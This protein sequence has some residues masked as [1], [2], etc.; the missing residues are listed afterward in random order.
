M[1]EKLFMTALSPT[2]EQGTVT[3]WHKKEGDAVS[4]GDVLCEVETD[5]AVM[6]YESDFDAVLLKILVN[7]GQSA[8]VGDVIGIY[9]EAGE[10]FSGL[11]SD[12]SVTEVDA[13][14]EK[15]AVKKE[16]EAFAPDQPKPAALIP[17]SGRRLKASPL[18]RKMA[19][20][21]N[22]N[23]E[24]VSGSGFDGR[25][26]KR[27]ILEFSEKSPA[28]G[29]T[30]AADAVP[31][32]LQA[33]VKDVSAMRKTIAQRLSASKF[34]AP[35]F[36]L[37][38][39]ADMTALIAAREAY[40]SR[41]GRK[42]SFNSYLI[43]LSA[44]ALQK[45]PVVNSSW[46]GDRIRGFGTADIGFA[47]ALKE[48]LITPVIRNC[49]TKGI[50]IIDDEFQDLAGRAKNGKLSPAEYTGAGF[51]ISNLGSYGI[52]EF[53]AIINPPGSAILAVGAVVKTPAVTT[54]TEGNDTIVTKPLVKLTLSCD[55]RVI[56]GAEGASFLADLKR[57]IENPV[58]ALM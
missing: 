47:A 15:P 19:A 13:P 51:T 24:A 18:A 31:A 43:R 25:I 1:A 52:E 27:D 14:P 46:E 35:H 58:E 49:E 10:D 45:H 2:M 50:L 56:D 6:E 30:A 7:N 33:T 53:T 20:D 21:L 41:T 48:G 22:I 36:Y 12:I 57:M 26:I 42:I 39:S 23:I 16:P 37:T 40:A 9:G 4:P 5:K 55:H 3:E 17:G 8:Q 28:E 54:D 44:S 34:S 32:S 29:Y 11:V 38:V